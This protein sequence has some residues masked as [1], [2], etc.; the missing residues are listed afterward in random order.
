MYLTVFSLAMALLW[1]GIFVKLISV[2]R[3]KMSVLQFFSVSP[4]M[5]VL[6]FCVLR[7]LF[8][9]EL[10]YTIVIDSK[11]IVPA[12]IDFL[13]M[14]LFK[15]G[16]I[17]ISPAFLIA[18]VWIMGIIHILFQRIWTYLHFRQLLDFLPAVTDRRLYEL[19]K[20]VDTHGRFQKIKIIVHSDVESPA[21]IGFIRPVIILPDVHFEDDELL[22]IFIH[23]IAHYRYRHHLIKLLAELISIC[24]WWNPL[25][26][27]LLSETAHAL[28][29]QSDQTVCLKLNARQQKEYINGILKVIGN[30]KY[31]SIPS[32]FSNSLVEDI[33]NEKLQQRFR[34]ILGNHYQGR[35]RISFII[36]PL[37][38]S[39]F[40]LSYGFVI[41]PYSEPKPSDYGEFDFPSANCNYF[42]IKTETGF[43]LYEY[44]ERFIAHMDEIELTLKE[45]RI[46][47]NIEEVNKK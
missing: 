3:R 17:S 4:L 18:M 1:T 29:M 11:A 45:L 13:A 46:Y 37:I 10:P 9:L 23:E 5:I 22:G 27:T 39:I 38:L 25:F 14:P 15:L 30:R 36:L 33:N 8:P 7:I 31:S 26:R 6:L 2:I 42:F 20:K 34:M 47:S 21:I 16:Y 12:T 24:F 28:E 43:D 35:K 41:Q 32:S 19:F 40:L 44:P